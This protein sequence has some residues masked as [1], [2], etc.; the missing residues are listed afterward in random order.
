M[1]LTAKLN[2]FFIFQITIRLLFAEFAK[3][4]LTKKCIVSVKHRWINQTV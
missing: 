1:L 3:K 4:T 2:K